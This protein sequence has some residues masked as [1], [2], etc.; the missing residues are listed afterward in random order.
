MSSGDRR[1][2]LGAYERQPTIVRNVNNG[3]NYNGMLRCFYFT[4]VSGAADEIKGIRTFCLYLY[5]VHRG[6]VW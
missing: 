5:R 3:S 2:A 1:L 4:D 6:D